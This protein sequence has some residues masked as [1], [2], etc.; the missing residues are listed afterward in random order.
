[1]AKK[2]MIKKIIIQMFLILIPVNLFVSYS[3]CDI[4]IYNQTGAT[5]RTVVEGAFGQIRDGQMIRFAVS[6]DAKVITFPL[7]NINVSA[8]NTI[9]IW[10]NEDVLKKNQ[11]RAVWYKTNEIIKPESITLRPNG[12]YFTCTWTKQNHLLGLPIAATEKSP[13]LLRAQQFFMPPVEK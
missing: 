1:M 12:Q 10:T 5:V 3:L 7:G 6:P 8:G 13:G 4:S 2:G 11:A 9:I